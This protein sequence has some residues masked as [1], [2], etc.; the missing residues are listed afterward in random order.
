MLTDIS[1]F[2]KAVRWI[3]CRFTRRR[4]GWQTRKSADL[5]MLCFLWSLRAPFCISQPVLLSFYGE[6][7]D[8]QKNKSAV[9]S[10]TKR[11][12]TGSKIIE[13]EGKVYVGNGL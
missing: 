6:F 5:S 9:I 1:P 12:I 13:N 2:C 10:E 8:M 11:S 3:F 7:V 4:D